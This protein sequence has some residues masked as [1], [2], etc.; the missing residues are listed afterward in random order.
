MIMS[1][2]R[3]LRRLAP[4]ALSGARAMAHRAAQLPSRAARANLPAA[5]DDS[6]SNLGWD[7][8]AGRFLSQPITASAGAVSVGLGLAPL[9]LGLYRGGAV[10]S[11]RPLDDMPEAAALEWLDAALRDQGLAPAA[12]VA[13]PYALP[14]E[15][16]D[17]RVYG[18]ADGLDVLAGWYS[19]AADLLSAFAATQDGLTPGPSPVRCW[20]HHFDI[21]TYVGLEAGD[22]ET[23]RGI[24]VGLS[25]GDESYGQPYFYVTP[26]PHLAAS[27]LP[28]PPTP[29]HWH[30]AGFVGLIATATAVLSLPDLR[31]GM[32]RFLRDAV[33]IGRARLGA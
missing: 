6:H 24:G 20:P 8:A 21:A 10:I 25:P 27:G 29:G 30:T 18:Q 31:G 3:L 11:E 9:T 26:W 33:E 4:G 5:A 12:P 1:E 15:A 23:A 19:F 22:S 13:P 28:T 7:G 32:A 17:V 2:E 16:Q 14:P